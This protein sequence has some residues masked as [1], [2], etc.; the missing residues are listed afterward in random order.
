MSQYHTFTAQDA[1]K[2]ARQFGGIDNPDSLV[3][4]QEIGD[5]NLNF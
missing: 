4:S 5:G 3:D 1:V 2:Y